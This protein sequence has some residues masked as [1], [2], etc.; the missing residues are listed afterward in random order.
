MPFKEFEFKKLYYSMG[1]VAGMFDVKPSQIRF[2]TK[3]FNINPK[4]NKK[5]NRLFNEEEIS[6]LKIIFTL[7]K[8]KGYTLQGARDYLK[9]NKKEAD[10]NQHVIDSL[11]KIKAF[12]IEVREGL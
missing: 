5:G 7:I 12:L 9:S 2:Y 1:E 11:E 8:E 10:N 6:Q 4:T 3:E